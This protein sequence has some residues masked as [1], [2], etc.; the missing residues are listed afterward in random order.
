MENEN[1]DMREGLR[2]VS[3]LASDNVQHVWQSQQK[4]AKTTKKSHSP[5]DN[6]S[7]MRRRQYHWAVVIDVSST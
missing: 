5:I 4:W 2:S 1:D 3:V 7:M 6:L